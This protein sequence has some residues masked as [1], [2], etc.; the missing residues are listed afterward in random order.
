MPLNKLEKSSPTFVIV[1]I[2]IENSIM[3]I[4]MKVCAPMYCILIQVCA[5]N[6][7]QLHVYYNIYVIYLQ[8]TYVLYTYTS[9]CTKLCAAACILQYICNIL[10]GNIMIV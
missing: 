7:V 6:C 8:V 9:V 3:I 10:S 2:K 4:F 5:Q 1:K